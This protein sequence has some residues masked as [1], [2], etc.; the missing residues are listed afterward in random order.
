MRVISYLAAAAAV[1]VFVSGSA[2]DVVTPAQDPVE[3]AGG[4][5]TT[6]G[7]ADGAAA[8]PVV[9]P[10]AGDISHEVANEAAG[11]SHAAERGYHASG[12]VSVSDE[13]LPDD[14]TADDAKN[15]RNAARWCPPI[16]V[17]RDDMEA[18]R[19]WLTLSSGEVAVDLVLNFGDLPAWGEIDVEHLARTLEEYERA[20]EERRLAE[21]RRTEEAAARERDRVT[22]QTPPAA[23]PRVQLAGDEAGLRHQCHTERIPAACNALFDLLAAGDTYGGGSGQPAE[24]APAPPGDEELEDIDWASEERMA[25]AERLR[26]A[27][28]AELQR[29]IDECPNGGSGHYVHYSST[30]TTYYVSC[31]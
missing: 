3:D 24:S 15:L 30:G 23:E 13:R 29:R 10:S 9:A 17:V 12:L 22:S 25:E 26:E 18:L 31:R 16:D 27:D 5:A 21:K 7:V 6:D 2:G 11:G 8:G 20:E 28:M 14:I 19:C 1:A 4:D